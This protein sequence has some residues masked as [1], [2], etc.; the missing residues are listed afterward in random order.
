MIVFLYLSN[1]VFVR[2]TLRIT[3]N[4]QLW[5]SLYMGEPQELRRLDLL[6]AQSSMSLADR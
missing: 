4:C 1:N 6:L 2:Q 5:T 3:R